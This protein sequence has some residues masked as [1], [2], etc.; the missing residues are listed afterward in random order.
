MVLDNEISKI[1][2]LIYEIGIGE[3]MKTDVVTVTPQTPM[4]QLREILRDKR[5]SGTPVVDGDKLVGIISIEDFI[6][7]LADREPDCP[8]GEKMSKNVETLYAD[9][10]LTQ[11]VNKF[12]EFGFGRFAVVDRE[13]G[14]LLGIITKGAIVEG[15]LKCT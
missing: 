14:R 10:P 1:Q 7:W 4:S 9:E 2:E 3:V 8:I 12:E 5:I 13:D 6:K 11:A 15:L